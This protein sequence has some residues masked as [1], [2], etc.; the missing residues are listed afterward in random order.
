MGEWKLYHVNGQLYQIGEYK[1]GKPIGEW[2]IYFDN[3][4]L[5]Q[6]GKYE[7]GELT[8][9]WKLYHENGQLNQISLW[10]AGK[11]MDILSLFDNKGNSLNKGTL[12]NG[13]G[14]VH[15]YDET[16]NQTKTV[17]FKDGVVQE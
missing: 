3:G 15:L 11:L 12:V 5:Y 14:T 1:E 6:I 9:E 13:N 4:Q 8:G 10:K 7:S 17:T 2:K 16:G